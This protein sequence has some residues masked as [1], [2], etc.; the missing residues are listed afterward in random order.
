MEMTWFNT[1]LST[2][3]PCGLTLLL[4]FRQPL[5]YR[6]RDFPEFT[7]QNLEI[8]SEFELFLEYPLSRRLYGFHS[9]WCPLRVPRSP[10]NH[11]VCHLLFQCF[12]RVTIG[13][14]PSPVRH[15]YV[16]VVAILAWSPKKTCAFGEGTQYVMG[17]LSVALVIFCDCFTAYLATKSIFI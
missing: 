16:Q 14:H 4:V 17:L 3:E 11:E 15:A 13:S 10:C 7:W 12:S 2:F 5:T 8:L 1:A 6:F 9:W